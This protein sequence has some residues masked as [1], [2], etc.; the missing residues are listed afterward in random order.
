MGIY[1]FAVDGGPFFF[2]NDIAVF[3]FFTKKGC[4]L[5]SFTLPTL[6]FDRCLLTAML[7]ILSPLFLLIL[8]R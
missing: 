7:A 2:K 5:K 6:S 8:V 4:S 3:A 1:F